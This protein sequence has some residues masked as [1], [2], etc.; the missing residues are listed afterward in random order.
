MDEDDCRHTMSE[1][2]VSL[3]RLRRGGKGLD[4]KEW[5]QILKTSLTT[6]GDH[7]ER[8]KIKSAHDIPPQQFK[9]HLWSYASNFWPAAVK[10][11][12]LM[13][14]YDKIRAASTTEKSPSH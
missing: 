3:K 1:V 12:K 13:A 11:T 10:S 8:E 14:M 4:R 5:A 6:I 9:K 7:I 2:R